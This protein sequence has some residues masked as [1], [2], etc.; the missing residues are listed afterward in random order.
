[1]GLSSSRNLGHST[2]IVIVL[3]L[4]WGWSRLVSAS[5]LWVL[6]V[7]LVG[8]PVADLTVLFPVVVERIGSGFHWDIGGEGISGFVEAVVS[9]SVDLLGFAV[10]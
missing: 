9:G 6:G 3:I 4:S 5:V 2:V 10:R 8:R 7:K 1:M